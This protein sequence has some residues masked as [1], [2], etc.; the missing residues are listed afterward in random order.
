MHRLDELA[1]FFDSD[2]D[3]QW[4]YAM[5]V[6]AD[7]NDQESPPHRHAMGQLVLSMQ[8]GVTC[9]VPQG[10]WMVPP[11]CGVWIPGGVPHSNRVTQNGR[12]CFLFVPPDAP[13]LPRQCCTLAITPLVR[14][15]VAHLADL[16][17]EETATAANRKLAE[18]LV[19]QLAR[20]PAEQLHL[21]ISDH[22][23]LREIADALNANPADR[24]TVAQWGK[25]VAMSERTLARLV[26]QELGMSF[27]R[28]RQQMHIIQALQRLSAGVS[29]QRTADDLGYESVSAFITM[30]R[31]ALGK[32]P[33]RYFADK[34]DGLN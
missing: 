2:I 30:F 21:P 34:A 31:K 5:R 19:E 8:G 6:H 32:T 33:A 17:P 18:V 15:L 7:E 3:S 11:Q 4:P 22:P 1:P 10:L 27:G 26:Q 12:V 28:W 23:R 9:S 29:V 24:S 16:A 25:R 14:E 20:M 13:G